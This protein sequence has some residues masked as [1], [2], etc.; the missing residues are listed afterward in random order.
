[1][2]SNTSVSELKRRGRGDAQAPLDEGNRGGTGGASPPVPP[3]M[4]GHPMAAHGAAARRGA[5]AAVNRGGG[6]VGWPGPGCCCGLGR[7][8]RIPKKDELGCQGELGRNEGLNRKACKIV[9]S[10][11]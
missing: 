1:V 3:S 7:H 8:G 9:F 2:V 5:A 6:R 11:F 10:F 4:G